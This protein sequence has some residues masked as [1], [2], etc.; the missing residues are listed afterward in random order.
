MF[1]ILLVFP[2]LA[3]VFAIRIVRWCIAV[4]RGEV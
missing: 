1:W 3:L 4:R 2:V